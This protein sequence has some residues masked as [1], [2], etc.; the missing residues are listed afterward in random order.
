M[1][2]CRGD[3]NILFGPKAADEFLSRYLHAGGRVENLEFW[4]QLVATWAMREVDDWAK[5]YPLMNRPDITPEVAEERVRAF[6]A[7]ALSR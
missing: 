4:D 5:V 7:R 1:A 6:A 2:T 3:L